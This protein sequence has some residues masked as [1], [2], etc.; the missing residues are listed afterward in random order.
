MHVISHL[1]LFVLLSACLVFYMTCLMPSCS[2]IG[3]VDRSSPILI[4]K[5]SSSYLPTVYLRGPVRAGVDAEGRVRGWQTAI[6]GHMEPIYF[7]L[8]KYNTPCT[9][10]SIINVELI[11]WVRRCKGRRNDKW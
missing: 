5:L 6:Q 8:R 2:N 9:D 10:S 3:P 11:W 1:R 4:N 7:Q